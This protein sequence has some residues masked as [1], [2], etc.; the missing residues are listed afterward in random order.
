MSFR[1]WQN[2]DDEFFDSVRAV[3]L[4]TPQGDVEE[5]VGRLQISGGTIDGSSVSS[6]S[7]LY[8][9]GARIPK[10]PWRSPLPLESDKLWSRSGPPA[11]AFVGLLRLLSPSAIQRIRPAIN[12][13]WL[14]SRT[15]PSV[16]S[17]PIIRIVLES[18]QEHLNVRGSPEF[19]GLTH[20]PP[21][22]ETVSREPSCVEYVGLHVDSIDK[23]SVEERSLAPWRFCVNIGSEER[24][25][26]F[27]NLSVPEMRLRLENKM[28]ASL[29]SLDAPAVALHFMRTFAHY[30]ILKLLLQ[31]GEAYVAPTENIV[32]DGCSVAVKHRAH[33]LALRGYFEIRG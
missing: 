3:R 7:V 22:L 4:Y 6:R 29:G 2:G 33:H 15:A 9:A 23:A 20:D 21:G 30:P 12:S 10:G 16:W 5:T 8:A 1:D 19:L 26:L 24:H 27:L 13:L 31:P 11:G 28:G 18:A 32:H 14:M 25:F 17:H